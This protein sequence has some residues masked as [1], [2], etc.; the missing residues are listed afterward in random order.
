MHG[1]GVSRRRRPISSINHESERKESAHAQP[2]CS[3]GAPKSAIIFAAAAASCLRRAAS[4]AQ[5]F[6]R[7]DRVIIIAPNSA[8]ACV[9][10]AYRDMAVNRVRAIVEG[11]RRRARSGDSSGSR[12]RRRA[13]R[14][15]CRSC[16]KWKNGDILLGLL[17]SYRAPRSPAWAP[18][19]AGGH[20]GVTAATP[21]LSVGALASS[22]SR[23]AGRWATASWLWAQGRGMSCAR[24]CAC[25]ATA[26]ATPALCRVSCRRVKILCS[27]TQ[28]GESIC[29][30]E[31]TSSAHSCA[32]INVLCCLV[33][34]K[35]ASAAYESPALCR[36]PSE[37]PARSRRRR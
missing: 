21:H 27:I 10:S 17:D 2:S 18:L 22:S 25:V 7:A 32:V 31:R 13:R 8:R 4:R 12:R 6:Y 23:R 26:V 14:L 29:V 24:R 36:K 9:S 33:C 19:C 34:A 35:T 11:P 37:A 30:D 15:R 16:A 3:W 20:H 5:A 1:H 28:R